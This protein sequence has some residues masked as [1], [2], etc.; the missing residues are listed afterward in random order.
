MTYDCEA[1]IMKEEMKRD[2]CIQN[3]VCMRTAGDSVI[4]FMQDY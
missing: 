1:W 3:E 4:I 2:I